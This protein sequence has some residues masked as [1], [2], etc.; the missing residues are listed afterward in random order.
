MHRPGCGGVVDPG[1]EEHSVVGVGDGAVLVGVDGGTEVVAGGAGGTALVVAVAGA[2][3]VSTG[4]G[5]DADG[6]IIC[7]DGLVAAANGE[8]GST[9]AA[10]P[11]PVGE[12]LAVAVGPELVGPGPYASAGRSGSCGF[13]AGATMVVR[14]PPFALS[15]AFSALIIPAAVTATPAAA[16]AVTSHC[17]RRGATRWRATWRGA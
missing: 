3:E 10:G 9:E 1:V 5:G 13:G 7:A 11:A 16:A 17:L 4:A 8:P 12:G 14:G 2:D 15:S 6:I